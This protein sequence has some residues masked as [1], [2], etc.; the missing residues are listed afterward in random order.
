MR[1]DGAAIAIPSEGTST[2]VEPCLSTALPPERVE[3]GV[4]QY[5]RDLLA[6]TKPG[7]ISLLLI[8]TACPMV[9][10]LGKQ[11]QFSA[12]LYALIGGAL[13][14]ASA[15]V[16]N[17]IWD[18]DIDAVMMRTRNRPLPCGR[19][20]LFAA[21]LLAAVLGAA[22]LSALYFLLNPLSAAIALFGHLFYV[23]VYTMVLKRSTVQNIVVGG[24]AGAVP[25]LVGWA[26][27]TGTLG[28]TPCLLCL[29]IFLW[30]PPH[31]WA[32][33]LN[34]N[35]DYRRARVPM[36]PVVRGEE[37]THLQMLVYALLLIPVSIALVWSDARLGWFSF[38]ALL[39][40][41]AIFALKVF[42][43]KISAAENRESRAWDVF[44]F[45]LI[46]LAL[47]FVVLVV[48]ST[49]V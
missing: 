18:R 33:A 6:L 30:T 49:V 4:L 21:W 26:A 31:F 46:Y 19:V 42:R 41:S 10:A 23:L 48:D 2:L 34:K 17:C 37:A 8:S 22:G 28:L 38:A 44:G 29:L 1:Q 47:F 36:M 25:P 5:A 9:L 45:S 7:V 16:I 20:S 12:M 35:S 24:L 11:V 13:T 14:S 39:L 3:S 15:G 32:L 43:L 27:A 40:L